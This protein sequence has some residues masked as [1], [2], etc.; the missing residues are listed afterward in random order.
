MV[1]ASYLSSRTSRGWI[2]FAVGNRESAF[3]SVNEKSDLGKSKRRRGQSQSLATG[4]NEHFAEMTYGAGQEAREKI[5]FV[6]L[7][8]GAEKLRRISS[9]SRDKT[10]AAP[11]VVHGVCLGGERVGKTGQLRAF[12]E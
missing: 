3:P 7:I 1:F 5:S 10:A 4:S 12:S 2:S 11:R 6:C 9:S 8:S